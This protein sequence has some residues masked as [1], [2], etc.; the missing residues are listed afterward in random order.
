MI[1]STILLNAEN[2]RKIASSEYW[3]G[4]IP[5]KI[6]NQ[7]LAQLEELIK[8]SERLKYKPVLIGEYKFISREC[9]C[10]VQKLA[11]D[12]QFAKVMQHAC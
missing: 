9:G 1:Y 5:R 7:Y 8:R 11:A 3:A 4:P 12:N 10:F 6:I 2:R